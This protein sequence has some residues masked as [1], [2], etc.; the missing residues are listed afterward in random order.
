MILLETNQK[1]REGGRRNRE[2]EKGR[3]EGKEGERGRVGKR[4]REGA[5][6]KKKSVWDYSQGRQ[7]TWGSVR[8]TG[9][10]AKSQLSYPQKKG[11]LVQG[12]EMEQ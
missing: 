6:S 11:K 5:D 3:E 9:K 1:D 7:K 12:L 4:T 10:Q 2:T 8:K